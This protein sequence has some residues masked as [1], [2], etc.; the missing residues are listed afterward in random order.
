[1]KDTKDRLLF[2]N[3]WVSTYVVEEPQLGID[4]YVYSHESRCNGRIVAVLPFRDTSEGRQFLLK[5]E[6]TPCWSLMPRRSAITGGHEGES[7]ETD[8]VRE[9]LEETGYQIDKEDLILLGTCYA[10]KSSDTIYSLFSVDLTGITPGI[11]QGD[12]SRL[13][14]EATAVWVNGEDIIDVLDAQVSVMLLRLMDIYGH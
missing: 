2:E 13:E 3:K 9:V 14:A 7:V 8:A 4:G 12:G 11:P 6:V 1:M 10:S 5:S